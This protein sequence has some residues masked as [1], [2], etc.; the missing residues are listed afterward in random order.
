[1]EA[2]ARWGGGRAWWERG[3]LGCW[4]GGADLAPSW[5]AGQAVG[6]EAGPVLVAVESDEVGAAAVDLLEEGHTSLE[7]NELIEIVFVE[8]HAKVDEVDLGAQCAG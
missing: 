8:A 1:M 7:L 2:L 3:G 4:E 5:L 6:W